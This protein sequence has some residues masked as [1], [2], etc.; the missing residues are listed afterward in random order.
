M[1]AVILQIVVLIFL[2][3]FGYMFLST[4]SFIRGMIVSIV[5]LMTAAILVVNIANLT[6]PLGIESFPRSETAK[7]LTVD[8]TNSQYFNFMV[9]NDLG[10]VETYALSKKLFD[11]V[12]RHGELFSITGS[13][14]NER[15]VFV[16]RRLER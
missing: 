11:H 1:Q 5:A 3:I 10:G 13:N 14:G 9:E 12:P 6:H 8:T 2:V 16:P 15:C 4:G 7:V